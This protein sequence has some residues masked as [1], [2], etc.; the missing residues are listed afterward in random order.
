[1]L[2]ALRGRKHS[3]VRHALNPA[4][5]CGTT[6]NWGTIAP[7]KTAD[8]V[9]LAGNPLVDIANTRAVVAVVADG[10]DQARQGGGQL[11]TGIVVRHDCHR[12]DTIARQ[13]CVLRSFTNATDCA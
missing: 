3:D 9:V 2:R 6:A 8:L 5:Y 13:S 4:I 10:L 11:T 1:M 7:G 12:T